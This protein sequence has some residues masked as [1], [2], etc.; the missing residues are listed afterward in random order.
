MA[1]LINNVLIVPLLQWS[2]SQLHCVNNVIKTQIDHNIN[3]IHVKYQI[4]NRRI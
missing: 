4:S 2:L 1:I 3:V